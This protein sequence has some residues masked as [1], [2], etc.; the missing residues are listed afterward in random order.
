MLLLSA[1]PIPSAVIAQDRE[2]R[3]PIGT[4]DAAQEKT[5]VARHQFCFAEDNRND[6][7]QHEKDAFRNLPQTSQFWLTEDVLDLITPEEKCAFL[8]LEAD[9]E[10]NEF[11]EQFWFRRA[12]DPTTPDNSFKAE[13][14]QRIAAANERYGQQTPWWRSDRGRVYVMF[15]KPDSLES[16]LSGEKTGRPVEEGPETYQFS[17]ERWHY[18]YLEGFGPDTNI[19]FIDS[20]G[21]GEYRLV[22]PEEQRD[23]VFLA[24]NE[25]VSPHSEWPK[26]LPDRLLIAT[27][28][29][30]KDLEAIAV[31]GIARP[32]IRIGQRLEFQRAT[33]A[34]TLILISITAS[35]DAPDLSKKSD[36]GGTGGMEIRIFYRVFSVEGK[37]IETIEKRESRNSYSPDFNMEFSLALTPGVYRSVVVIQDV[38]NGEIGTGEREFDIPSY[39]ELPASV[40]HA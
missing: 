22:M 21:S 34:T 23:I 7:I 38:K 4:T 35:N 16:H 5:E 39:E 2:A 27:S 10:R 26:G 8:H 31:T 14:Y 15:G 18:R 40:P 32:Q 20:G 12:S 33:Q 1:V 37:V 24:P 9:D 36:V 29:Q 6:S 19:D 25:P 30:Y 17:W 13:Y 28:V 11:I 3:S